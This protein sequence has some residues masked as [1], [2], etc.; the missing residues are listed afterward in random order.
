MTDQ[1]EEVKA[2]QALG[3]QLDPP[4]AGPP[5]DVRTR[6][7]AGTHTRGRLLHLPANVWRPVAAAAAAAVVVVSVGLWTAPH[8]D[9]A[10]P[11]R[12]APVSPPRN[13]AVVVLHNAALAALRV[14]DQI[15]RADQYIFSES[16]E[17]G[18]IGNPRRRQ[19]WHSVDGTHVG[20]YRE[21]PS[22]AT[23]GAWAENPLNLQEPWY[24][25]DLPTTADAMLAY[26]YKLSAGRYGQKETPAEKGTVKE[27]MV[28]KHAQG[29]IADR[30]MRPESRA[31][32]F[33]ALAKVPG[34]KVEPGVTDAVGRRGTAVGLDVSGVTQQLVF[35]PKTYAFLGVR[36]KDEN[37]KYI[38]GTAYVGL[39]IVDRPGQLP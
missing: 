34:A 9:R 14:S 15:P 7:L 1:M 18:A 4:Q 27:Q 38:G 26:L 33:E 19:I 28:W 17:H 8:A 25:A 22:S 32:L 30:Y 20:L 5:H 10:G 39:A 24:I 3:A 23:S 11:S 6:V 13:Q 36:A 2:L 16:V 37:G 12:A 31:A 21:R 35:D 29:L